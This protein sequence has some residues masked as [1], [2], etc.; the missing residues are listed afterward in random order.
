MSNWR[1]VTSNK[2]LFLVFVTA[3]S[4]PLAPGCIPIVLGVQR[5]ELAVTGLV[6][7]QGVADAV[8]TIGAT[9]GGEL[10]GVDSLSCAGLTTAEC[11]DRYAELG[12]SSGASSSDGKYVA[13][14]DDDGHVALVVTTTSECE[15][16]TRCCP[17]EFCSNDPEDHVT[18]VDFYVRVEKHGSSEIL[19]LEFTPGNTIS[20]EFFEVTVVS[21]GEPIATEDFDAA[22]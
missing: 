4:F 9:Q 20:G 8:V 3:L 5:V 1:L 10:F 21:I 11:L 12:T 14:S 17:L 6:S 18:G 22:E 15:S 13:S 2:R 7:N 19:T 16:A